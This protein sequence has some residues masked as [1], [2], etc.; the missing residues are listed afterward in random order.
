MREEWRPVVGFEG[1]YEVSDLGRV[2]SV[3]GQYAGRILRPGPHRGGYGL[4]HL[5]LGRDRRVA[6]VHAV[7]AAAFIG[8][9]PP[10]M[11][12]CHNDGD[13]KNNRVSNLRYDTPRANNGDKRRH[14]THVCGEKS[15]VAK[16]TAEQV[17]E[18]RALRG[19]V[20]QADIAARFGVTFSNVS[21]I[22]LGKSW[23]HV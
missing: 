5:Y 21:A 9:R 8:P 16:I 1:L 6:T 14:G 17:L 4:L 13:P 3:A 11:C 19:R 22:Q 12:V 7:V 10:G 23:R 18:I 2:R 15:P 20:K